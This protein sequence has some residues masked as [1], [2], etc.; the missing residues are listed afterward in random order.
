MYSLLKCYSYGLLPSVPVA[1]TKYLPKTKVRKQ[2]NLLGGT[3]AGEESDVEEEV[4]YSHQRLT[5]LSVLMLLTS[6][7]KLTPS[8]LTGTT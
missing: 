6:S 5:L 7:P 8:C 2:K 1:L 4:G 3:T